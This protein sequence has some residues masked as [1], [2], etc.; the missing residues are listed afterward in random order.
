M[1]NYKSH[2]VLCLENSRVGY[3]LVSTEREVDLVSDPS[4]KAFPMLAASTLKD[5]EME[6]TCAG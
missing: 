3:L 1:E 5:R 4:V 6:S 2:N